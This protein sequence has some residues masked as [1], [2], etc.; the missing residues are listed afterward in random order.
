MHEQRRE[1]W[2]RRRAL[3]RCI[4]RRTHG[5][6]P[7]HARSVRSTLAPAMPFCFGLSH[8]G[9][10][11]ALADGML[12]LPTSVAYSPGR[13]AAPAPACLPGAIVR[14]DGRGRA[15]VR[16]SSLASVGMGV[17]AW[18]WPTRRAHEHVVDR[19]A[20]PRGCS[21]APSPYRTIDE[22]APVS[23]YQSFK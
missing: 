16:G 20:P 17:P 23:W 14:A 7:R 1:S 13:S 12:P 10:A 22:E 11:P 8:A 19:R 5:R 2:W 9:R 21:R 18:R 15:A 6:R 4:L 3:P